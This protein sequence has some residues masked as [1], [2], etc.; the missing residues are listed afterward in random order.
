M[1]RTRLGVLA[2]HARNWSGQGFNAIWRTHTGASDHFIELNMANDPI[3]LEVINGNIP[4]RGL[5]QGQIFMHGLTYLQFSDATCRS[6]G[7]R[8][9]CITGRCGT[10]EGS[11]CGAA[12]SPC[13]R[14]REEAVELGGNRMEVPAT[15][16]DLRGGEWSFD[17]GVDRISVLPASRQQRL[18]RCCRARLKRSRQ[19]RRELPGQPARQAGLWRNLWMT[20]AYT[21]RICGRRGDNA[22]DFRKATR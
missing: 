5:V 11:R 3:D 2:G 14:L 4:N 12:A 9:G 10:A 13:G 19:R 18:S 1:N 15:V 7:P 16:P 8:P 22:V 17:G 6:A 21:P 20:C